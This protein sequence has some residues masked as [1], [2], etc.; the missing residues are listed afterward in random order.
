MILTRLFIYNLPK[1]VTLLPVQS[2]CACYLKRA[3]VKISGF[4]VRTVLLIEKVPIEK[5]GDLL[6]PQIHPK[7]AHSSGFFYVKEK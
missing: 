5:M 7:N 6:V 4:G 3:K 2:P 1:K